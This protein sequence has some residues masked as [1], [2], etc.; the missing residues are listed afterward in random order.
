MHYTFAWLW[1]FGLFILFLDLPGTSFYVQGRTFFFILNLRFALYFLLAG[2]LPFL[3]SLGGFGS[4]EGSE[5]FVIL[6]GLPQHLELVLELNSSGLLVSAPGAGDEGI[7]K[8]LEGLFKI[9]R[10]FK[11]NFDKILGVVIV[12]KISFGGCLSPAMRACFF[13]P[14][15]NMFLYT[16]SAISM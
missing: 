3:L 16:L 6:G 8:L 13:K 10:I 5:G 7:L 1:F 15:S 4:P 12:A 11:D 2:G 14:S 9:F